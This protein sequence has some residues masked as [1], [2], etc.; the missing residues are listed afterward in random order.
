MIVVAMA[1]AGG[2]GALARV[3]CSA[4]LARRGRAG[5][6]IRTINITGTL[7]LAALVAADPAPAWRQVIGAGLLGGFTTFSTWMVEIDART[8]RD[9]AAAV[10]LPVVLALAI[11]A[12]VTA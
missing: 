4:F 6:A 2:L 3:E 7:L 11:A 12:V 9:R 8:G 5:S 1:L 10:A